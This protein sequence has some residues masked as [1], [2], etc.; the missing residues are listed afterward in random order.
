MGHFIARWFAKRV[1]SSYVMLH[2]R[3]TV[4]SWWFFLFTASSSSW[5]SCGSN[6]CG[7]LFVAELE[8]LGI[9]CSQASSGEGGRRPSIPLSLEEEWKNVFLNFFFNLAIL[10]VSDFCLRGKV[11][12]SVI[13]NLCSVPNL[14]DTWRK[15]DS[16]GST[17]CEPLISDCS[18]T[19][20]LTC[21]VWY[22]ELLT[23]AVT[24]TAC[25]C[26]CLVE[27]KWLVVLLLTGTEVK[28]P[29][30]VELVD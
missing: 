23:G 11:T 1:C 27:G 12:S 3:L 16:S 10:L 24:N 30:N 28:K 8:S 14:G 26:C 17:L 9:C 25:I 18:F 20:T 13:A 22:A 15:T 7:G 5:R 21:L 6:S 2:W 19:S 29:F 4:S